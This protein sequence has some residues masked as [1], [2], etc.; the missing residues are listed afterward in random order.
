MELHER[1]CTLN[2]ERR[3]RWALLDEPRTYSRSHAFRR[4]LPRWLRL[5][6][7]LTEKDI[8]ELRERVG[9]CPACMLAALRQSGVEY[10]YD[11]EYRRLWDYD[12]EIKRFREDERFAANET[13]RREIEASWL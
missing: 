2:P 9:S 11:P 10:H 13:E 8:V 4:G 3:C 12:E 6:A 1:H 5:R 7:P